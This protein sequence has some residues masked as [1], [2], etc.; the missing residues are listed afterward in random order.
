MA[1]LTR[2]KVAAFVAAELH[3]GANPRQLA[4]MA[5]AYLADQKQ[6]NQLE[7]LIRDIEQ[8]L[9][10]HHGTVAIRLASARPLSDQARVAIQSFVQAAERAQSS[11]VVD[12]VVNPDLIGGVVVTTPGS[13]FDSSVRTQLRQLVA[14]TKE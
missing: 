8:A 13:I 6:T 14:R 1:K 5:V 10:E 2:R 9:A 12:E 7:M 4:Q 3:K 11:I